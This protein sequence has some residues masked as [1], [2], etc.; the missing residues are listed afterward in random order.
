M[1]VWIDICDFTEKYHALRDTD[2]AELGEKTAER[3]AKD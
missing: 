3:K 2:A 1:Y